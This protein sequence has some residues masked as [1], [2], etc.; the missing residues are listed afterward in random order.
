M[1]DPLSCSQ[2]EYSALRGRF[3]GV[4]ECRSTGSKMVTTL[5]LGRSLH[6][7]REEY[8]RGLLCCG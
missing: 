2:N 1:P 3:R 6:S 8:L 5:S 7:R 4:I